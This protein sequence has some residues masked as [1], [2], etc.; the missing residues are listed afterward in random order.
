MSSRL[1]VWRSK[2]MM[3]RQKIP[4]PWSVGWQQARSLSFS[5][6]MQQRLET[7]KI[8]GKAAASRPASRAWSCCRGAVSH[9]EHL[10]S[11]CDHFCNNLPEPATQMPPGTKQIMWMCKV[12]QVLGI[13][14]GRDAV[15]LK[16]THPTERDPIAYLLKV[17]HKL[18]KTCI[19]AKYGPQ[20]PCL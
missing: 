11:I 17:P 12:G 9:V 15:K 4:A 2:W 16:S 20:A 6:S 18:D 14:R 1:S 10:G 3:E 7:R 19:W 5:L 13:E 8:L